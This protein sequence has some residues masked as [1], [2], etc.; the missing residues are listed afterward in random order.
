MATAEKVE[1]DLFD[2]ISKGIGVI[3]QGND[4]YLDIKNGDKS[5]NSQLAEQA[6]QQSKSVASIAGLNLSYQTLAVVGSV[7]SIVALIF[8]FRK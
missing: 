8:M 5:T 6:A 4:T 7:A 3:S 1:M 2:Y